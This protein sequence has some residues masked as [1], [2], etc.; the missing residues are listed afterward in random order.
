VPF[1]RELAVMVVRRVDGDVATYPV[2]DTVQRDHICHEV[3]VPAEIPTDVAETA[4]QIAAAAVVAVAGVGVVG[5]ELFYLK[6]GG[7]LVNELAPRPHNSG[8]YTIEGC[9]ASQFANHLRAI[10]GWKLGS[11]ELVAPAVAMVNLLGTRAAVAN[12]GGGAN[13]AAVPR[14]FLH[15]Y[16]KQQVRVG[17][18][19]GHVTAL[20]DSRQ[21]ALATARRAAS[22]IE[23]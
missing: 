12:P 1:E 22:L 16:G 6:D 7:I 10:L 14:A 23:W 2:V 19:M 18:K 4:R 15:F 11:T 20:G 5:V 8:H 3:V 21:Q 17:R 13:A 9:V